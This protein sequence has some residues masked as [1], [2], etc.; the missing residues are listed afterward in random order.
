MGQVKKWQKVT[1]GILVAALLVVITIIVTNRYN[2]SP[3]NDYT[4][5]EAGYELDA[6]AQTRVSTDDGYDDLDDGNVSTP[7]GDG[8]KSSNNY[9][10]TKMTTSKSTQAN[11]YYNPNNIPMSGDAIQIAPA[12]LHYENGELHAVCYVKNMT[13]KTMQIDSINELAFINANG[14]F[15][16]NNFD[17]LNGVVL[18]PGQYGT[19]DFVF[20]KG[21]FKNTNLA[22][23]EQWYSNVNWRC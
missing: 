15:A 9:Y 23:T 18:A 4:G 19:Y 7:V 22:N 11:V 10:D 13:Q 21:T 12:Y 5:N 16:D 1:I 8:E 17:D 20:P 14:V 2:T 3:G 6:N